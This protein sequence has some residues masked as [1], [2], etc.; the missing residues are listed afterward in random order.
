MSTLPIVEELRAALPPIFAGP[1]MDER[2]GG[3]IC[4]GTIQNKRSRKE[5]PPECFIRSGAGPTIVVR[6]AFLNWWA[7]TLCDARHAPRISPPQPRAGRTRS[8]GGTRGSGEA[9]A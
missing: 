2:T 7:T 8:A 5:I 4:W 3:A 9:T 1:S 6:D